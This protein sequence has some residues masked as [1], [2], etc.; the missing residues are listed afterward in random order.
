M[1][2]DHDICLQ[3]QINKTQSKVDLCDRM[4]L[5]SNTRVFSADTATLINETQNG[6]I[7]MLFQ[8]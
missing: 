2:H 3:C 4:D 6:Y 8:N 7:G 5:V 1:I